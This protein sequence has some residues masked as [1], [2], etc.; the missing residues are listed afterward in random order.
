MEGGLRLAVSPGSGRKD[1]EG[2]QVGDRS[3]SQLPVAGTPGSC[4]L[5]FPP[6]LQ[7]YEDHCST[8]GTHNRHPFHPSECVA[9]HPHW[10]G[11][12]AC[13]S[14]LL[15]PPTSRTRPVLGDLG[16]LKGEDLQLAQ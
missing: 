6:S 1:G 10:W 5:I 14:Q 12:Q 13:L 15:L 16:W 7:L 4:S 3:H 9:A 11:I 8:N 2:T